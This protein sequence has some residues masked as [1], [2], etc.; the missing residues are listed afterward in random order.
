MW[1]K[2]LIEYYID[3]RLKFVRFWHL[4]IMSRF[5]QGNIGKFKFILRRKILKLH[6]GGKWIHA[7]PIYFRRFSR[8]NWRIV[9]CNE[10][11]EPNERIYILWRNRNKE[12][13]KWPKLISIL[14][15]GLLI[16]M[17]QDY[18][19][20]ILNQMKNKINVY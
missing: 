11:F 12:C 10:N 18:A 17:Q 19:V 8:R 6:S 9:L 1:L 14:W 16:S 15:Q 7:E 13:R 4:N 2:I 3:S 20:T 5:L